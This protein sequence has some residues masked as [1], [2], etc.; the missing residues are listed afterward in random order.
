MKKLLISL[1]VVLMASAG[2]AQE[3]QYQLSTHILDISQGVPAGDVEV[4]LE[5]M[6]K[7]DE[8]WT[9][10]A[11]KTTEESGRIPD[12][13][14]GNENQGIYRFTFYTKPYFIKS[15]VESFYPIVQ[16]VFEISD[17]KHYHVPITLSAFG[18]STYRGS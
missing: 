14:P 16:V 11:Q 10:V 4:K 3:K 17:S 12:F 2:F 8:T 6:N 18:Y 15:G 5:K 1:A 13:L 9:F 7:D